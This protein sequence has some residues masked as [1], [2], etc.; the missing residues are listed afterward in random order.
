MQKSHMKELLLPSF[1]SI[2]FKN[3]FPMLYKYLQTH[4]VTISDTLIPN[5]EY[6]YHQTFIL[7]RI[8]SLQT[9]IC[10]HLNT[11]DFNWLQQ[12]QQWTQYQ[13]QLFC[14]VF[15][16][17]A[18]LDVF[19]YLRIK[20][21]MGISM[22]FGLFLN[23]WLIFQIIIFSIRVAAVHLYLGI[24]CLLLCLIVHK[25]IKDFL[26]GRFET[27]CHS[28]TNFDRGISYGLF[29]LMVSVV[30]FNAVRHLTQDRLSGDIEMLIWVMR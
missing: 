28:Y 26:C 6:I 1:S 15:V 4:R 23:V 3:D 14:L 13:S 16:L 30:L 5:F 29:N 9:A 11:F 22:S 17:W 20:N 2:N 7:D 19:T 8:H 24:G 25:L 27:H 10:T 12:V 18:I 21:N